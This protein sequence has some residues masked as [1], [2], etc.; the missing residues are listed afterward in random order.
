MTWAK[1]GVFG[2]TRSP[3]LDSKERRLY[4]IGLLGHTKDRQ[5]VL[6]I[7]S[8]S[9]H[10]VAGLSYCSKTAGEKGPVLMAI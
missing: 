8:T 10:L 1:A 5:G 6:F 3:R 4:T 7:E 2:F 9:C